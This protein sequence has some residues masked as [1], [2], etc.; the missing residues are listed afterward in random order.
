MISWQLETCIVINVNAEYCVKCGEIIFRLS[1]IKYKDIFCKNY[2]TRT[3]LTSIM[4]SKFSIL[5]FTGIHNVHAFFSD[6]RMA[7]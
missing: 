3:Y 6:R 4:T 7:R 1:F 5:H 2:D